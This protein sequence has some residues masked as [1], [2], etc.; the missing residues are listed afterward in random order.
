[1]GQHRSS[2]IGEVVADGF[3][4]GGERIAGADVE[5]REAVVEDS[6]GGAGE[7]DRVGDRRPVLA[8]SNSMMPSRCSMT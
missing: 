8:V 3:Q 4:P 2:Y 5:A 6:G 1:M 7:V